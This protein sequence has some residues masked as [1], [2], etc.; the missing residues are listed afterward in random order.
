MSYAPSR[1]KGKEQDWA[2]TEQKLPFEQDIG[3]G[4]PAQQ[5]GDGGKPRVTGWPWLEGTR[6]GQPVKLIKSTSVMC[7]EMRRDESRPRVLV[8]L[9]RMGKSRINHYNAFRKTSQLE[10]GSKPGLGNS[11]RDTG[12]GSNYTLVITFLGRVIRPVH[13]QREVHKT[14]AWWKIKM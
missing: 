2:K 4:E 9:L 12:L 13:C 5:G 1:R 10:N 6:G 14:I 8:I 7:L 3:H 11:A